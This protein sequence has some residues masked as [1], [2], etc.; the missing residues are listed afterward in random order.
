MAFTHSITS[1]TIIIVHSSL[2]GFDNLLINDYAAVFSPWSI[3]WIWA[4]TYYYAYALDWLIWK[5]CYHVHVGLETL[6]QQATLC[7]DCGIGMWCGLADFVPLHERKRESLT[8]CVFPKVHKVRL[9]NQLINSTVRQ[10]NF[11]KNLSTR[12]TGMVAETRYNDSLT[13][14][15]NNLTQSQSWSWTETSTQRIWLNVY[16]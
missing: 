14:H 12:T 8:S 11:H 1:W 10:T 13:S 15:D 4:N 2:S 5:S 7:W 6:N 16:A 3:E 9:Q